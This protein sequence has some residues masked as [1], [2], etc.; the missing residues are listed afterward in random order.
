MKDVLRRLA[1]EKFSVSPEGM[2]LTAEGRGA[3]SSVNTGELGGLPEVARRSGDSQSANARDVN[4]NRVIYFI[5]LA[6]LFIEYDH[7]PFVKENGTSRLLFS[8][9]EITKW[10]SK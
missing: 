3:A 1:E 6:M 8:P 7:D 9:C 10:R 5:F 2:K 4:T